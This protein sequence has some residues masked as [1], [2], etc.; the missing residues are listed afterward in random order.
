MS[1]QTRRGAARL[2]L[3]FVAGATLGVLGC[4]PGGPRTYP[5]SGKID[6]AGGDLSALSGG[7]IDAALREDPTV[8]A[9]GEIGPDG[10]F[11]LQTLHAGVVRQGAREGTY[12]LRIILDDTSASKRRA[13]RAIAPRYLRFETSG[14]SLQVPAESAVTLRAAAR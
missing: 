10:G 8:R 1:T 12:R 13:R 7:Y 11:T 9:S 5:V 3:V 6:L 2:I 14:L 4:G